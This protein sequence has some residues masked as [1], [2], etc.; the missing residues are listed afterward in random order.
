MRNRWRGFTLIEL[1]VVIA[2]IAILIGLLVPAVQKV[3]EAAARAKCSNNIKQI[4]IGMHNYHGTT[5]KFMPPRGDY[6]VQYWYNLNP[7]NNANN[8]ASSGLYPGG[9]TQYGGWMLN[10][11]PYIE[12]DNLRKTMNYTGTNWVTPFFG[13]YGHVVPTFICPSASGVDIIPAGDGA[14]TCYLGVTG[15]GV[16]P[17]QVD[18]LNQQFF[19]PSNGIFNVATTGMRI[20]DIIDG[21]TNTLMIGERRPALDGYWGWWSVSDYDCLL[22]TTDQIGQ[23]FYG[24][25]IEPGYFGPPRLPLTQN[26]CSGDSNH[27]WSYHT[28]GSNWG[29][30]DGSVRFMS[31]AV[32]RSLPLSMATRNGNEVIDASQF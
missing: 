25:C 32:S 18:G 19:G 2:I 14:F 24:G 30:G 13:N 4:A 17:G 23:Y 11:L 3:R 6:F 7:A 12:Q 16:A 31:Y 29:L 21:T 27:F 1:L 26:K 8:I 22:S 5:G 15:G 20:S 28:N 9:F 10:L